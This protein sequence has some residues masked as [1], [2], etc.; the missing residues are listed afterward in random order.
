MLMKV[1][2]IVEIPSTTSGEKEMSSYDTGEHVVLACV[3]KYEIHASFIVSLSGNDVIIL[4]LF[5]VC[6]AVARIIN[7]SI[8]ESQS[9]SP[10]TAISVYSD[11]QSEHQAERTHH[12][13]QKCIPVTS[14]TGMHF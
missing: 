2:I 4:F 10:R 6:D 13:D 8:L 1:G 7:C 9:T 14:M 3:S 5:F 12:S 11:Q